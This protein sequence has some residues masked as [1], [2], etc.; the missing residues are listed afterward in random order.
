LRLNGLNMPL[1][2]LLLCQAGV[3]IGAVLCLFGWDFLDEGR[4][5]VGAPVFGFGMLL[6][7][8][9]IDGIVGVLFT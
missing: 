1:L 5:W 3:G 7:A 8:L 4:W 2:L 9:G 6:G